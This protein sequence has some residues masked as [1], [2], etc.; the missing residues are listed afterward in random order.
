MANERQERVGHE[1]ITQ[2][3]VRL[4]QTQKNDSTPSFE[5]EP[6][7]SRAAPILVQ[8]ATLHSIR[9]FFVPGGMF[10]FSWKRTRDKSQAP[11]NL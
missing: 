11:T 9:Y 5:R 2:T 6:H 10:G 3:N 4:S 1:I 8:P 7:G